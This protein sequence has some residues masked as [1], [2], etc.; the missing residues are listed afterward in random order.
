M[1]YRPRPRGRLLIQRLNYNL[2]SI[3][4]PCCHVS[5]HPCPVMRTTPHASWPQRSTVARCARHFMEDTMVQFEPD[6]D[7]PTPPADD[8]LTTIFQ[9]IETDDDAHED[10]PLEPTVQHPVPLE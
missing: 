1:P 10:A 9:W 5:L 6:D 3:P 4:P 7:A 2:L 8:P